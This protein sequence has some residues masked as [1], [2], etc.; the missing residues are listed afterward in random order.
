VA[1]SRQSPPA[2]AEDVD[3]FLSWKAAPKL[4]DALAKGKLKLPPELT[5][6][7]LRGIL[8]KLGAVFGT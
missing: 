4:F 8:N 2:A 6:A 3:D 1:A 7:R 5:P